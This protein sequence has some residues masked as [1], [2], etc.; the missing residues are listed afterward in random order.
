MTSKQ[1]I[2][3]GFVFIGAIVGIGYLTVMIKGFSVLTRPS[4]APITITFPEVVGLQ[5]GEEVRIKGV[6]IGQV[7]AI[8]YRS[9]GKV[10]VDVT[11]FREPGL[12]KGCEFH[13]RSKSPLGGKFMEIIPGPTTNPPI[14]LADQSDFEGEKPH[15]LYADL[16]NLIGSKQEVIEAI[17]DDVNKVTRDLAQAK[18][19]LGALIFDEKMKKQLVTIVSSINASVTGEQKGLAY[20][21]LSDAELAAEVRTLLVN[22][23][24]DLQNTDTPLGVLLKDARAGL[25]LKSILDDTAQL[26]ALIRKGEGTVGKLITED[27]LYE[28]VSGFVDGLAQIVEGDGL[29]ANLIK[30]PEWRDHGATILKSLRDTLVRVDRGESTLGKLLNKSDIHDD[31]KALL[32]QLRESVEDAREQAPINQLVNLLGAGL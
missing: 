16:G 23:S 29:A 11:L 20:T 12:R 28:K 2:I 15:D 30:N 18:G 22:L 31:L 21:L 32:V 3:V 5:E 10:D 27:A 4:I 7:G 24:K 17:I 26:T 25:A 9:D 1:N 14:K 13:I 19:P 8:N 6:E